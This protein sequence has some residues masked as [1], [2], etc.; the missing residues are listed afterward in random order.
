MIDNFNIEIND[1]DKIKRI[2]KSNLIVRLSILGAF[3]LTILITAI[4]VF[5][6][7]GKQTIYLGSSSG[8]RYING[9]DYI[10]KEIHFTN[11][12]NDDSTEIIYASDFKVEIYGNIY[13]GEFIST[14][15]VANASNKYELVH[16]DKDKYVA[17]YFKMRYLGDAEFYYKGKSLSYYSNN[18]LG[19]T[20]GSAVIVEFMI[21]GLIFAFVSA[22]L[23][24]RLYPKNGERYKKINENVIQ[25]L[26]GL[27]F[28]TTKTFVL[29][30]RKSGSTDIEKMQVFVDGKNKKLALVDYEKLVCKVVD[31]KDVVSYKLI[32]KNGTDV[33]SQL[34]FSII[35]DSAYT[36]TSSREVC[37]KLQLVFVLNDEE[38]STL[39][40]ELVRSSIGI[41]S[42]KYKRLSNELIELTAFLDI[43][44]KN[45]PKD[46]R[47]VYCKHCGT[48]NDYD[49]KKCSSCGAAID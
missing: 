44:E 27:K 35:L 18:E 9:A 42:D 49:A 3:L 6:G 31:Y 8:S 1:N 11:L 10:Y 40:Y 30:G 14:G 39:I 25:K 2:K 38:D 16:N 36:T 12:N 34:H 7:A 13:F 48:K 47:F 17:V 22:K 32:E 26:K 41:D 23:S 20:F 28:N 24:G 37:K 33:N 29:S 15:N 46:K 21:F 4:V 19:Y 43:V 45:T 5:A